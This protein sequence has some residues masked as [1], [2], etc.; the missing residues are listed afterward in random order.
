MSHFV[1]TETSFE[2]N[3]EVYHTGEHRTGVGMPVKVFK[4]KTKA[5]AYVKEQSLARIKGLNG[6]NCL[7]GYGYGFQ[8]VTN[9]PDEFVDFWKE[10]TGRDAEDDCEL[11]VPDNITD[12]Q[13]ERLY[14][15]LS[16]K[17]FNLVEVS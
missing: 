7:G 6:W 3:D 14:E 17:F 11:Q 1:V 5:E 10:L 4:S 9:S 13:A 8:E 16:V 2:Y 12:E 15:L